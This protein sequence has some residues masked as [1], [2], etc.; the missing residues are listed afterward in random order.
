MIYKEEID[1]YAALLSNEEYMKFFDFVY[2]LGFS[3]LDDQS[4]RVLQSF[5]SYVNEQEKVSYYIILLMLDDEATAEV[6]FRCGKVI[7]KR[8]IKFLSILRSA[9]SNQYAFKIYCNKEAVESLFPHIENITKTFNIRLLHSFE[10]ILDKCN[11]SIVNL[12]FYILLSDPDTIKYPGLSQRGEYSSTMHQK[13]FEIK[14]YIENYYD[15]PS[16]I[17]MRVRNKQLFD[18]GI[19]EITQKKLESMIEQLGYFPVFK[20]INFIIDSFEIRDYNI[21]KYC[22]NIFSTPQMLE[23]NEVAAIDGVSRERIR[24]LRS[25]LLNRLQDII[26]TIRDKNILEGYLY[27]IDNEYEL[28]NIITRE[29]VPYNENFIVW[30]LSVIYDKYFIIG[31]TEK[32]FFKYPASNSTLYI[33]PRYLRHHFDFN[34]F[35]SSIDSKIREKRYYDERIDLDIFVRSLMSKDVSDEH[36]Y[37]IVRECRKILERGY[38]DNIQNSQICLYKNARKSIPELIEDI[39]RENNTPMTAEQIADRFNILY[40]D[41]KQTPKKISPNALRNPNISAIS[42][43]STYTLTEWNHTEKRGGTIRDLAT[44]YLNSLIEPIAPLFDICDYISQFRSEVKESSIKANLLAEANNKFS[45]YYKGDITYIGYTDYP[46][47][48]SYK[49]MDKRLGGRRSF[50]ESIELLENFIKE[51]GRF[52]FSSGVDTEELRLSR[53]LTV[54][55]ANLKKGLLSTDER[56]AIE[57]IESQYSE[58]KI[59]KGRARGI[60]A[61]VQSPSWNEMLERFVSYITIN[62]SIP[63]TESAEYKWYLESKDLFLDDKLEQDKVQSFLMVAKIV[64]R[65]TK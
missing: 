6:T 5:T 18:F 61:S 60:S 26:I 44:E 43:T 54:S 22:F 49:I 21:I 46:F 2:Y 33:I 51:N 28:R 19:D 4:K 52:P 36:F 64:D 24:Q 12:Y 16:S 57:R 25:S 27:D 17:S 29:E 7:A 41:I 13:M 30:T 53:F 59:K 48:S 9:L 37:I 8:I 50:E 31:D 38:P 39:L 11:N 42:R 20:V 65:M 15:N 23:M 14:S 63:S 47:N 40:P 32:V 45:I 62:E 3:N 56:D 55:R 10:S 34:S 35:I 58:R 1:K